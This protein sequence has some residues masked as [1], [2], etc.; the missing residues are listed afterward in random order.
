MI[1]R[2]HRVPVLR[3]PPRRRTVKLRDARPEL[4][5][6]HL[7]K[8][9]GEHRVITVPF[10]RYIDRSKRHTRFLEALDVS[11]GVDAGANRVVDGG[12]RGARDTDRSDAR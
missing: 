9:L 8:K 1:D 6:L 2:V 7:L 12:R 5:P 11:R 4:A 10:A 3:M